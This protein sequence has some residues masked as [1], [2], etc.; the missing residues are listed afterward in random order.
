M[1]FSIIFPTRDRPELLK[2]L[3]E[4]FYKYTNNPKDVEF[5][6]AVDEDDKCIYNGSYYITYYRMP[7]SDNFSRDYFNALALKSTGEYVMAFNDDVEFVTQDWDVKVYEQIKKYEDKIKKHQYDKNV[8]YL[9][10]ILD[11]MGAE[12][13]AK[14]QGGMKYPSFPMLPRASITRNKGIFDEKRPTWG[15]DKDLW[16]K[17]LAVGTLN[18]KDVYFHHNSHHYGRRERDALSD[19]VESLYKGET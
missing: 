8:D 14:E 17:Y 4:S 16:L 19:R 5:L 10:C 11:D 2:K 18:V 12:E 13:L 15:A 1:K 3:F 7:R 9:I 6:I